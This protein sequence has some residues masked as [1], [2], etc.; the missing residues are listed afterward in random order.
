[1]TNRMHTR[2]FS[3]TR[4]MK[5]QQHRF[6]CKGQVGDKSLCGHEFDILLKAGNT[7]CT[8][9]VNPRKAEHDFSNEQLVVCQLDHLLQLCD[10]CLLVL[11]R[12]V[13]DLVG[14]ITKSKRGQ[15]FSTV[16]ARGRDVHH[17]RGASVST[18]RILFVTRDIVRMT[19]HMSQVPH[20]GC[21]YL[22][23][24]CQCAI[25]VRHVSFS[26]FLSESREDVAEGK[27]AC[28]DA[29]CLGQTV[30]SSARLLH[31]LTAC[32]IHKVSASTGPNINNTVRPQPKPQSSVHNE[33]TRTGRPLS[34]TSVP[35]KRTHSSAACVKPC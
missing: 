19:A 15:A 10:A 35:D 26:A 20:V 18:K 34:A 32:E 22:Q 16:V 25:A 7:K 12:G 4:V 24:Q 27:Q 23:Q 21:H 28:V 8:P 9:E 31:L 1:M 2:Q 17:Q 6:S 13:S 29:P 14:A 3:N 5:L 33:K 30:S 11:L